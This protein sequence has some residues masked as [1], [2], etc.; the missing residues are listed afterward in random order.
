MKFESL[1]VVIRFDRK[2]REVSLQDGREVGRFRI[3]KERNLVSVVDDQ[4]VAHS[5]ELRIERGG[6]QIRFDLGLKFGDKIL[7]ASDEAVPVPVLIL[8]GRRREWE[9]PNLDHEVYSLLP[10]RPKVGRRW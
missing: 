3:S 9:L 5:T 4:I 1:G 7:R 6:V 2:R 10:G 8:W